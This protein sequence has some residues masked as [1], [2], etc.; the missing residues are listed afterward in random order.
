MKLQIVY[1]KWWSGHRSI[2]NWSIYTQLI[3]SIYLLILL[4]IYILLFEFRLFKLKIVFVVYCFEQW[5]YFYKI[6][7]Q[8]IISKTVVFLFQSKTRLQTVLFIY[9]LVRVTSHG[10]Y[11]SETV[12][13]FFSS[14]R[15]LQSLF[16]NF[17]PS[18]LDPVKSKI[19]T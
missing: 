7:K 14:Y 15:K 17:S 4:L 6:V 13:F 16:M 1:V 12:S 3:Y 19:R 10:M 11:Y 2:I 9:T 18:L 5:D 8:I